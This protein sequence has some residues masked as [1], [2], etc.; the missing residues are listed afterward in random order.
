MRSGF[1]FLAVGVAAGLTHFAAFFAL[2]HYFPQLLP[3]VAN[4]AAFCMAFSVSF[5]GHRYLSFKDTTSTVK[6]S[7]KR[8]MVTSL[9]GLV[10]NNLIF[11]VLLRQ[12]NW[13]DMLG[14]VGIALPFT[15]AGYNV[16]LPSF[17]ALTITFAVVAVQTFLLSRFWAFHRN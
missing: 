14:K 11:S 8:F 2:T 17:L 1:W 9:A 12:I 3:E 7:L 6:Q 4:F 13:P 10:S 16:D 15:L 5:M